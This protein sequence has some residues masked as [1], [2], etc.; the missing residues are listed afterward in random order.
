M[1][2]KIRL[3]LLGLLFVVTG[4]AL[5]TTTLANESAVLIRDGSN[6]HLASG[7]AMVI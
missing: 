2:L 6:L 1:L 7:S 3:S 4:P 5:S